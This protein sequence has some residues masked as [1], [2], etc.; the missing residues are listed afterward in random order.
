MKVIRQ[1]IRELW[2]PLVLAAAWTAY[3]Q[4][5]EERGWTLVAIG[6]V[7]APTFF[8]VSWLFA[9]WHRVR[10]QQHV[11]EGIHTIGASN[12]VILRDLSALAESLRTLQQQLP[13]AGETRTK[14]EL[15]AIAGAM[16]G[17]LE[18]QTLLVLNVAIDVSALPTKLRESPESFAAELRASAD[19]AAEAVRLLAVLRPTVDSVLAEQH[20]LGD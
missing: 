9:Q 5:G 15:I 20:V 17:I 12:E 2:I 7:F 16:A 13:S 6:S 10:K 3:T 4:F 18:Q 14:S 8:L 19:R 11:E 1:L